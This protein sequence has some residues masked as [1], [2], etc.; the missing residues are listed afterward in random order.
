[1]KKNLLF[2]LLAGIVAFFFACGGGGSGGDSLEGTVSTYATDDISE[3]DEVAAIVNGVSILNTGTGLKCVLLDAPKPMDLAKLDDEMLL[4]S[5]KGCPAG[6]YNRFEVVLAREVTLT[7]GEDTQTCTF[8]SYKDKKGTPNTLYCDPVTDLCSI[9]MTGDQ[10]VIPRE[11]NKLVLDFDLKEFEVEDFPDPGCTVTM[12]VAPLNGSEMDDKK[13]KGYLESV[14]G[15]IVNL[16]TAAK[17]FNIYE[18]EFLFEVDYSGVTEPGTDELLLLAQNEGLQVKVFAES[19]EPGSVIKATK[20][21]AEGE[22]EGTVSS[23]DPLNHTFVL[24]LPWGSIWIDYSGAE[25]EDV[26]ADG[27]RA[28]VEIAGADETAY[29][30][31]EVEVEDDDDDGGHHDGDHDGDDDDDDERKDKDKDKDKDKKKE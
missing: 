10:S 25:V 24:L 8:T 19:I 18:D 28:E 15:K 6:D 14:K 30:A 22:V 13:D 16:H 4:I 31:S 9:Q 21:E 2:L 11:N 29:L 23:L 17:T 1:M 20:I 7:D 5:V 3:Y 27:A 12:K 26:L